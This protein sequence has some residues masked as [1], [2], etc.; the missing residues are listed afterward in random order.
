LFE[1]KDFDENPGKTQHLRIKVPAWR[2]FNG[3]TE[4]ID[5]V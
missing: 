2:D 1:V 3:M 4:V 5:A